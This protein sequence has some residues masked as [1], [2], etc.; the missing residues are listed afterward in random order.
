MP[1]LAECKEM[2]KSYF[3]EQLD[4]RIFEMGLGDEVELDYFV[5]TSL[6]GKA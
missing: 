5:L 3:G 6:Y 4:D 2:L 1:K